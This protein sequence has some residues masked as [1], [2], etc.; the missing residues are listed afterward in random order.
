MK[1]PLSALCLTLLLAGWCWPQGV[2]AQAPTAEDACLHGQE[3]DQARLEA[4][5]TALNTAQTGSTSWVQLL[6]VRANSQMRLQN[7]AAARA[8]F[9]TLIAY[10]AQH[11][12]RSKSYLNALLKR[13]SL[14]EMEKNYAKAIEDLTQFIHVNPLGFI[15]YYDRAQLWLKLKAFDRALE[16][17]NTVYSR[18]PEQPWVLIDRSDVWLYQN[19]PTQ[20]I[21]DLHL[22]LELAVGDQARYAS[23]VHIHL[24][25]CYAIQQDFKQAEAELALA[26]ED[27]T[28]NYLLIQGLIAYLQGDRE[29]AQ[30]RLAEC[31]ANLE[32]SGVF[33]EWLDNYQAVL[34][35]KRDFSDDQKKVGQDLLNRAKDN[36]LKALEGYFEWLLLERGAVQ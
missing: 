18:L 15:S 31:I 9:D 17:L 3:T 22:A 6:S 10:L 2:L 16:D 25:W 20:A 36:D 8:D 35:Q 14:W 4:C 28:P 12:P 26:L 19:E 21:K 32:A 11:K 7:Y 13:A 33:A 1:S 34:W 27:P 29:R 5:T 24:A 30:K 23:E